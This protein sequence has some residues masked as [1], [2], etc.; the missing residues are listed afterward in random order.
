MSALLTTTIVSMSKTVGEI[1]NGFP[2]INIIVGGA[3]L[4]ID[5]AKG[6]GASGYARDPQEAVAWLNSV[7]A[8]V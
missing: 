8:A 5:I 4:T 2:G 1:R 6:M 7:R 3:P